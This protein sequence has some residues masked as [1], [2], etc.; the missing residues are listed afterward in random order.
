MRNFIIM[1][2]LALLVISCTKE[3]NI[4]LY[5]T[6]VDEPNNVTTWTVKVYNEQSTTIDAEYTYSIDKLTSTSFR[7]LATLNN[8]NQEV[9]DI[10]PITWYYLIDGNSLKLSTKEEMPEELTLTLHKL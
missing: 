2:L 3:D 5:G 9:E 4:E 6:W 7:Q 8:T 1:A 10:E